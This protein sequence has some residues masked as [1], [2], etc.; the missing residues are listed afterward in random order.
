MDLPEETRKKWYRRCLTDYEL[1]KEASK[2]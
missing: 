1:E 2:K